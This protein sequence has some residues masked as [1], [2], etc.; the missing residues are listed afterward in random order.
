MRR[1][2]EIHDGI[3]SLSHLEDCVKA[4]LDLWEMRAPFGTYNVTNP[5]A[6]TTG[7][8]AE[9]MRRV[10]RSPLRVGA[11]GNQASPPSCILDCG[12]LLRAGVKLRPVEEAL[13]D[14]LDRLR[15]STCAER[16]LESVSPRFSAASMNP[17][18]SG[19]YCQAR[20]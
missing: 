8:V 17:F 16:S 19:D 5:G 4:C 12:K 13:E 2:E 6:I 11:G 9:E 15:V 18:V 7:R 3:H 10:L 14:C 20:R 1:Q